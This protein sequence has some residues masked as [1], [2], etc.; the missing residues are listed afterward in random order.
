MS[1]TKNY[2]AAFDLDKT[3]LDVNSSILVVKA[4]RKVGYMR[5]RDFF[6]AIYYSIVYQF[7]LQDPNKIVAKMMRWLK[8]LKEV[9][10]EELINQHTIP[11]LHERFRPEIIE[12]IEEHRSKG[13][14]L[15]L[16]SSAVPYLCEPIASHLK[17]DA[18]VCSKL[19]SVDGIFTGKPIRKLV[20]GKEKAVRMK[21][22]CDELKF[23]LESAWYYGDA[24]TDRFILKSV[25]NPVCVKPEIK[26][27]NLAKR[28]G[29]KII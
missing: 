13:A 3:I 12:A 6:R 14:H 19:E 9:H 29:W 24:F 26:L 1:V 18:V 7:D 10:V 8:G 17:M 22:Y 27:R 28:K 11:E 16:L 21:E 20:F 23:T 5:K 2:I 4:S 15:L 25:G